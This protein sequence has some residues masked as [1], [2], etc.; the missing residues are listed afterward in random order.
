V[1][2]FDGRAWSFPDTWS[3]GELNAGELP[4]EGRLQP[5]LGFGNIWLNQ[6]GI[7]D[8]LGWATAG[9]SYFGSEM[10][11]LDASGVE[12]R[13]SDGRFA[14]ISGGSWHYRP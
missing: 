6:P 8:A 10:V 4:P 13:L 2:A 1:L 9:E 3:G 12:L 5:Q 7:R 14:V 11:L